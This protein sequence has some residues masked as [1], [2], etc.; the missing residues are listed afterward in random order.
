MKQKF[1]QF[2]KDQG[3]YEEFKEKTEAD[4]GMPLED[5]LDEEKPVDYI[6]G[7]FFWDE[8]KWDALD[9]E[10]MRIVN[11]EAG[12]IERDSYVE[13]A[14]FILDKLVAAVIG[15]YDLEALYEEWKK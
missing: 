12:R 11:G 5:Y 8:D 15:D 9:V 3:V 14:A 1:I 10:W 13:F 2:L 6:A 7:A 4:T